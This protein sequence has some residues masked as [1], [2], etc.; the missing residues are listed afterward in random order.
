[1]SALDF[2]EAIYLRFW[3]SLEGPF[4][5]NKVGVGTYRLWIVEAVSSFIVY[6]VWMAGWN[7][8]SVTTHELT[9]MSDGVFTQF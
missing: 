9:G 6:P 7:M 4:E 3:T 2:E 1:M 5:A 8:T